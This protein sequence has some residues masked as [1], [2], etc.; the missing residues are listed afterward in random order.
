MSWSFVTRSPIF[1]D[2]FILVSDK[3]DRTG[4]TDPLA[5][6]FAISDSPVNNKSAVYKMEENTLQK[7]SNF[8]GRIQ[9]SYKTRQQFDFGHELAILCLLSI[10]I[11]GAAMC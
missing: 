10:S 8:R 7:I 9:K 5:K 1:D 11:L 3:T 2:L 6:G 4:E